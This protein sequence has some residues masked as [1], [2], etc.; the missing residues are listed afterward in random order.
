MRR[1][2]G[3][4]GGKGR[5]GGKI[6]RSICFCGARRTVVI[7]CCGLERHEV[8]GFEL[9]PAFRQRML[10]GLVLADRAA[11]HNSLARVGGGLAQG[12][13]AK[14]DG[15]RRDQS[16]LGIHAVQ[17]VSKP[18]PSSP[19]RSPTGTG[20]DSMNSSFESTELRPI[21]AISRT[22]T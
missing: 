10:D 6:F 1:N 13:A 16:A 20:N 9:H 19:I 11:K 12:G 14:A 17:N 8:G 21:L 15:L 2:R 22:S 5:L 18:L 3:L 4:A 7:E